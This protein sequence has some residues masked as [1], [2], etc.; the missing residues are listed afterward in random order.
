MITSRALVG[1]AVAAVAMVGIPRP[2]RAQTVSQ[3]PNT[4]A[5]ALL[6]VDGGSGTTGSTVTASLTFMQAPDNHQAGGPDETAALAFT[7][8][9]AQGGVGNP[10]TLADCTLNADG[11]PAAVHPDPS[12][13][14]FK[15]VV[16]NASCTD[17]RPHCLCNPGSGQTL[18]NFIN[19]VVYGPNPLPTPGPNPITIPILP[20]GPPA[21]LTIDLKIAATGGANIPLH[22]YNQ[23]ED[24]ASGHPQFTAFFSIGD[25][26][27]ADQTCVPVQNI[28]PCGASPSV[29]QVITNDGV[30]SVTGGCVGD[31]DHSG[32][33]TVDEVVTM[34][35]I[36]LG[37]LPVSAC[38]PGDADH[39]NIISVGEVQTAINNVLTPCH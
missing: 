22:L 13:S 38:S 36:A 37:I 8:S 6:K 20:S 24:L 3:C 14:D 28:P 31:C 12:I 26:M 32:L 10:L 2:M 9:L 34:A 4:N 17:S 23:V 25:Q 1:L 29:S 21:F 18:D 35:N 5:C 19:I 16:E 39:N 15:V 30:V 27:A 33:V 11:L 7:L